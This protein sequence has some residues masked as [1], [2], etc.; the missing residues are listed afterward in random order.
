MFEC[1]IK[2]N[3]VVNRIQYKGKTVTKDWKPFNIDFSLTNNLI[4][5]RPVKQK[6]QEPKPKSKKQQ[7]IEKAVDLGIDEKEIKDKTIDELKE[8]IDIATKME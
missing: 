5:C 7:L 1:R 6:L 2:Q 3:R 8:E 4:E